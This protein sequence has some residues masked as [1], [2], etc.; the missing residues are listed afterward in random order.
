[1]KQSKVAYNN[2]FALGSVCDFPE[3]IEEG[4][5]FQFSVKTQSLDQE[6]AV[7]LAYSPTPDKSLQIEVCRI[8]KLLNSINQI[9]SVTIYLL[10]ET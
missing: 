10:S 6:C 8:T 7:C 2:V 9:D 5:T 4:D 1:M 3:G